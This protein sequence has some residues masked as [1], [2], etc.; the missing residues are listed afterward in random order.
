[1]EQTTGQ[2]RNGGW[3]GQKST[4]AGPKCLSRQPPKGRPVGS[5]IRLIC[6]GK[7][8]NPQRV[9]NLDSLEALGLAVFKVVLDL[10]AQISLPITGAGSSLLVGL[11]CCPL[12]LEWRRHHCTARFGHTRRQ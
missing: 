2:E 9:T 12:P 4:L 3:P 6:T 5:R 11:R 7:I 8:N 1:M 10:V